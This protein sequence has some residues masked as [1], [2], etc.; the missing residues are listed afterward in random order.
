MLLF[1][2]ITR[3]GRVNWSFING[4]LPIPITFTR[5]SAGIFTNASGI[6]AQAANNDP[7]FDFDPATLTPYGLLIEEQRTNMVCP[8]VLSMWA[9]N[10]ASVT[11]A[12]GIAPD[13]TNSFA[14]LN[15]GTALGVHNV[16]PSASFSGVTG[17]TYVLSL[18]VKQGTATIF[19]IAAG[20]AVFGPNAYTNFNLA[21]GTVTANGA[22]VLSS[23]ITPVGADVYRIGLACTATATASSAFLAVAFTNDSP[24]ASRTPAYTG[25]GK[26]VFAWGAQIEVGAGPTSYIPTTSSAATRAADVGLFNIPCGIKKLQ[27]QFDDDSKQEVAV[28]AGPYTIPTSLSR[29]HI[30]R[31]CTY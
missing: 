19:Q 11:P 8:S 14:L 7:R 2:P 24:T 20:S 17:T 31:I 4:T 25:S 28:S 13:G 12:S 29:S 23:F 9:A 16:Y 10:G 5:G 22:S 26:T 21:A 15:E 3:R 18:Y 6:M 1:F 27:Y 30:K